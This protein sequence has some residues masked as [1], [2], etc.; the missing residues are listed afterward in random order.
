MNVVSLHSQGD[1]KQSDTDETGNLG[2][3]LSRKSMIV[4]Q[5]GNTMTGNCSP[6]NIQGR[7][8][9]AVRAQETDKSAKVK[10]LIRK[11][12]FRKCKEVP[13]NT[14]ENDRKQENSI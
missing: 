7:S 13:G 9:D 8:G 12:E 5:A 14:T 2:R 3:K 6:G 11:F 10:E 1:T 4:S